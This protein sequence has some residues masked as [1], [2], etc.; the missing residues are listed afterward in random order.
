[1]TCGKGSYGFWQK[2]GFS[3]AVDPLLTW[4][5]AMLVKLSNGLYIMTKEIPRLNGL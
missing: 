4:H 2:Q 5:E 3:E 1:M